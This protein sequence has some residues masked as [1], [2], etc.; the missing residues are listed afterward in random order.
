MSL[1]EIGKILRDDV[2]RLRVAS[3]LADDQFNAILCEI[4][5]G[6]P[7]P[8]GVQHIHNAAV[9]ASA[10]RAR[11]MNAL[12]REAVFVMDGTVPEDLRAKD[13]KPFGDADRQK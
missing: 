13:A 1:A 11:L 8:D 9:E 5:S 3:D 4:P 6:L 12:R 7:H 10:A 2:E